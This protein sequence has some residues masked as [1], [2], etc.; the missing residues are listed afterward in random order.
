M[1]LVRRHAEHVH[2]PFCFSS[3]DLNALSTGF[4]DAGVALVEDNGNVPKMNVGFG[5]AALLSVTLFEDAFGLAPPQQ[6]H[7]DC[8]YK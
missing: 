3:V 7:F 6:T 8:V 2:D 1:S 5:G 4:D